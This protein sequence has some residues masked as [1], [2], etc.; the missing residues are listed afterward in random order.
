M[1]NV[2]SIEWQLTST[3]TKVIE[4]QQ[5]SAHRH[6]LCSHSGYKM[7]ETKD[8]SACRHLVRNIET[9]TVRKS[10]QCCK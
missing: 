1:L 2:L 10:T 7:T 9:K 6:F 5:Q 8:H 4:V 3:Q